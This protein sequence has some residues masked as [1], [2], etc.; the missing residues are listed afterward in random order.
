MDKIYNIDTMY[1]IFSLLNIKDFIRFGEASRLSN[2]I[3]K[4]SGSFK[5]IFIKF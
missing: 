4:E 2:K 3:S 5:Q 1:N